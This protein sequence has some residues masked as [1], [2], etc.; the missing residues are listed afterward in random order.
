[1]AVNDE[2]IKLVLDLVKSGNADATIQTLERLR[3]QTLAAKAGYE[4]LDRQV[5]TYEV[6]E[7][8]VVATTTQAASS[9]REFYQSLVAAAPQ[10]GLMA[11]KT[12]ELAQ[13]TARV[14]GSRG[15]GGG[16]VGFGLLAASYAVQDFS[17]QL[18][19]R[20]LAGALSA[21]QNNI[22]TIVMSLGKGGPGMAAAVSLASIAV[23]LLAENWDKLKEKFL[24][25]ETEAARKKMEELA[26]ATK[27]AADEGE[28]LL[29]TQTPDQKGEAKNIK[30]AVDA[31]GGGDVLK[32]VIKAM[33]AERGDFGAEANKTLAQNLI[34]NVNSGNVQAQEYLRNLMGGRGN[35]IAQVLSGGRTPEEDI[36]AS[37]A[38]SAKQAQEEERSRQAIKAKKDADDD[39]V[40]N[41][42]KQGQENEQKAFEEMNAD[43]AKE[44]QD[45][46][47]DRLNDTR[48][49][50]QAG[51]QRRKQREA[52]S[53]KAFNENGPSK[54][55]LDAG[56]QALMARYVTALLQQ[57]GVGN[58]AGV[59]ML[60]NQGMLTVNQFNMAKRLLMAQQIGVRLEQIPNTLAGQQ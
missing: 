23:G 13:A 22:P 56:D 26:E 45:A 16:N 57:Q 50:I 31:F 35:P 46:S 37:K 55:G 21:V 49:A 41:L 58:M 43:A 29:K 3:D 32:E 8:Q 17:S 36:A 19:T 2:V 24:G 7:R 33:V 30:R 54:E 20:G 34:T 28:R 48:K 9:V 39:L 53:R 10:V 4:I 11:V 42:N 47:K 27:K 52:A 60:A 1:M 38:A 5:G 18:G 14:V 51:E 59:Q 15:G 44:K 6:M 40:D 25:T 12:E